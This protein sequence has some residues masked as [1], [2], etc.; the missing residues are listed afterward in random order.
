MGKTVYGTAGLDTDIILIFQPR[1]CILA[2]CL[3]LALCV[4]EESESMN[5][6]DPGVEMSEARYSQQ[7]LKQQIIK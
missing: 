3:T 5:F 1:T 4:N 2:L 6:P 7:K